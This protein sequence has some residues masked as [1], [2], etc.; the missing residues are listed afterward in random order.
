M[1]NAEV[2]LSILL[3]VY[4]IPRQS[5]QQQWSF[6]RR[7]AVPSTMAVQAMV[8]RSCTEHFALRCFSTDK[9]LASVCIPGWLGSAKH[10]HLLFVL[11]SKCYNPISLYSPPAIPTVAVETSW[12]ADF[13]WIIYRLLFFFYSDCFHSLVFKF[14]FRASNRVFWRLQQIWVTLKL[15]WL[16]DER[17]V[18]SFCI[19]NLLIKICQ[20]LVGDIP[21]SDFLIS[22]FTAVWLSNQH[23]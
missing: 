10:S 8:R 14:L 9:F 20:L 17:P 5:Q 3:P 1:G 6:S 21:K 15:N 22:G 12:R 19:L 13:W 16:S 4:F 2:F 23:P 18:N 11:I 7:E